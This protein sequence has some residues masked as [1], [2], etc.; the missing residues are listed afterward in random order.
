MNVLLYFSGSP[1][2]GNSSSALSFSSVKDKMSYSMEKLMDAPTHLLTKYGATYSK[3]QTIIG[4]FSPSCSD[5]WVVL[6][7]AT[8]PSCGNSSM[9]S[10][11]PATI[12][13]WKLAHKHKYEIHFPRLGTFY[14]ASFNLSNQWTI[15]S[16]NG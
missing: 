14:L 7:G 13:L 12:R 8:Q 16:F 6:P 15:C 10:F 3:N 1:S 2:N 4:K 9:L 11:A 5:G